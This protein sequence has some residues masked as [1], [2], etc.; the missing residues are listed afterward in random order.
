MTLTLNRPWSNIRTAHRLIIID[1]CAELIIKPTNGSKHIETDGQTGG[2][3]D[4]RT[5]GQTDN[6]TKHT[7]SPHEMKRHN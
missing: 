1:M 4:G 6:E 3:T 2:Q 7:M 5:Y